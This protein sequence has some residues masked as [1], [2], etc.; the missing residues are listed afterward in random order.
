MGVGRV[1]IEKAVS[2]ALESLRKASDP[3]RLLQEAMDAL[4]EARRDE[5]QR[6]GRRGWRRGRPLKLLF[7]G[8]VGSR[9]TGAD[10]RT[11]EMLRQFRHLLGEENAELSVF[12][13]DP[14]WTRSYF[15]GV[16]QIKVPEIF[17]PFL[18]QEVPNHDGVVA[19]EGSMFKSKFASALTTMMVGAMGLA[20]AEGKIA[21]GYGGEA[22][23]MDPSLEE[24]V[25]KHVPGSLVITRNP[26]STAVLEK[27]GIPSRVGTDTAWSFGGEA[28][29]R[30]DGLGEKLLRQLGW[31]GK[32]KVLIVCPI[33]PF[34]WPVRPSPW[35]A[36]INKATKHYDHIHFRSIYF[37]TDG[38]EVE[39][40]F[41]TYIN[42]LAR[43]SWVIA[44]RFKLFPVVV[45]ME[46]LDREAG[47]RFG[48]VISGLGQSWPF[49]RSD[50]HDMFEVVSL[51]RRAS[52]IVSS[53]YHA[54]V[55]SMPQGVPAIGVTM[56]ERIR[57]LMRDRGSPELAIEV[58]D[59]ALEGKLIQAALR[60]IKESEKEK[61]INQRMVVRHLEIM[62]RMGA[63]V[64][65]HIREHHPEFP[66]KKDLGEGGDPWKHL[67]PL[68]EL[69]MK[70]VEQFA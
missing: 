57:N 20:R 67:P 31:D 55:C 8:Y 47:I 49:V 27:L 60:L 22:G 7:A 38:P 43:A 50:E 58:D 42:H 32:Q 24:M 45:A 29:D 17:P 25:K 69:Q 14:Q 11:A 19:C 51:L 18:Y 12:T 59:P 46:A 4:I 16:E 6:K 36:M 23:Y 2:R 9:N 70:I 40:K 33:N 34:W 30:A 61:E 10:V 52:L 15:P 65:D 39:K 26:E 48:E 66:F 64:V 1:L 41:S 62:G 37:H 3:D 13:I 21:I 68:P 53:R 44:R 35:K 63:I 54:I 5:A 56:D 28:I